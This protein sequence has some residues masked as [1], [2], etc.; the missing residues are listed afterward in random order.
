MDL[1]ITANRRSGI[2]PA[3]IY[4]EAEATGFDVDNPYADLRYRWSFGDPGSYSRLD[5][6]DLPWSNDR[7]LAYGPHCSHVFAAPGRYRVR[8]EALSRGMALSGPLPR[9]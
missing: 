7:D 5:G 2:A 9:I 1:K 4:F 3:G 6:A 8:C